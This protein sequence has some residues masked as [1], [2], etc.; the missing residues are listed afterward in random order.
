LV[1]CR[2]GWADAHP[3]RDT[4][5]AD[6]DAYGDADR[7]AYG[8]A[9][10]DTYGH[11]DCDTHGYAD[12]HAFGADRDADCDA[13]RDADRDAGSACRLPMHR[14]GN[15]RRDRPGRW[16]AH[17]RLCRADDGHHLGGDRDR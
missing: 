9:D 2:P 10:C 15:S 6:T 13:D 4:Y 1:R 5:G 7:N 3:D 17:L 14:A 16:R 12:R 8:H 11:A